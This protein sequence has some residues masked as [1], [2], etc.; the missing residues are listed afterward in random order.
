MPL[1]AVPEEDAKQFI[2][3]VWNV[4]QQVNFDY[5]T[6][7]YPRSCMT[8]ALDGAQTLMMIPIQ[9]VLMF[10][11]MVHNPELSK[12][13]IALCMSRIGETVEDAMKLTGHREAYFLTN[14]AQEAETC[15]NHGWTK[16]LYDPE[17]KI[18]L[19]KK[20]IPAP[21]EEKKGNA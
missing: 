14:D 18:Y 20:K 13:K 15:S 4:R 9:P 11:S 2:E 16:A 19:M 21:P 8:R 1:Y 6:L 7:T 17:K 10:E 5:D 12:P 3:W